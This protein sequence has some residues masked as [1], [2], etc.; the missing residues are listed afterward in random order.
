MRAFVRTPEGVAQYIV[1]PVGNRIT[2]ATELQL[3][4]PVAINFKK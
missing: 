2:G 1:A 4:G 3:D